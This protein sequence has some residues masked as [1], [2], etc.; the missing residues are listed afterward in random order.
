MRTF[1]R[2]TLIVTAF[3]ALVRFGLP[4]RQTT[5]Q[6][7]EIK[8]GMIGLDTSH[9]TAFAKLLHRR[10]EGQMGRRECRFD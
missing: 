1:F 8:V 6:T 2:A 3:I 7:Q 9:V 5:A 4:A 10:A